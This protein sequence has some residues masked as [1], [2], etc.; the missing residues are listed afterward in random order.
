MILITGGAGYIGSHTVNFFCDKGYD[1]K[2]LDNLS[3]G[4]LE[5]INPRSSFIKGDLLDCELLRSLFNKFSF[6]GVIHLAA[7][8]YVNESVINPAKYYVNNVVGTLNLLNTMVTHGVKRLVFSSSCATYGK[9]ENCPINENDKQVPVSPY[10]MSK[11][12]VEK[13]LDDYRNAYGLQYIALRY[14]NVAGASTKNKIG[15]SHFPETHLIPIILQKVM[16]NETV[17][18]F[19]DKYCTTDGTCIRD[20]VHV[21]DIARA[22]YLAINKAVD[23]SGCINLGR[24]EGISN[25]KIIEA[26]ERITSQRCKYKFCKPRKGDPEKICANINKAKKILNWEPEYKSID[27]IVQTALEWE[28]ARYY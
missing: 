27:L 10:G 21:M 17:E 20:Y 22:N 13:I 6:E 28:K 11:L 24:G 12:I 9:A 4:H 18:I 15:E 1:C 5:S 16:K 26:V 7:C 19:G 25:L 2:V 23:Y 8:A 14:F 3:N